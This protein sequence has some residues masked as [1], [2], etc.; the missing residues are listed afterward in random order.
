MKEDYYTLVK[1]WVIILLICA[2]IYFLFFSEEWQQA[3]HIYSEL[4][5]EF[6]RGFPRRPEYINKNKKFK[7]AFYR[8]NGGTLFYFIRKKRVIII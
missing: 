5:R 1:D 3:R 2:L 6:P 4:D 7:K 8:K